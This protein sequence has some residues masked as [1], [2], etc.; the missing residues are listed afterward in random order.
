MIRKFKAPTMKEAMRMAKDF[1]GDD[2]VILSSR[3]VKE[4]ALSNTD[5]DE[6]V[7]ITVT[8]EKNA[9]ANNDI[10]KVLK[11]FYTAA[12]AKTARSKN[13]EP[14]DNRR[15]EKDILSLAAKQDE[16]AALVEKQQD[17]QD[18]LKRELHDIRSTLENLRE[19]IRRSN[20]TLLPDT[21]RELEKDSGI[22]PELANELIQ[23]IFL[24][25]DGT[26]IKD[27]ARIRMALRAEI[28]RQLN[29]GPKFDLPVGRPK[30]ICMVG[31]TGMGKT[32][33]I[34]KLAT[35]PEYYGRKRVGLITIDTYRVA[36][37]AQ[38]KTF[39]A[40]AK[41]PL[42]IVYEPADFAAALDKMREQDVVLI[43]TAGRSP[44]NDTHLQDLRSIFQVAQPDEL[45]LV[46]SSSMRADV[47]Y[48][49]YESFTVL[50]VNHII[51]TKIDETRRLGNILNISRK[52]P[53]PI[54]FLTNGQKVPDDIL[55]ADKSE[56]AHLVVE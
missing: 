45:H 47:L 48:D 37:A 1:F 23:N 15:Y 44:L 22:E 54:S 19:D 38:L 28:V 52:I 9:S 16:V 51:I 2:A 53:L 42:E 17:D 20:G 32:T 8:G 4:P 40:L 24:Q 10:R 41:L 18:T 30:L 29:V 11:P 43:D 46:L 6:M 7:E 13:T 33:T 36:A 27:H 49:A 12:S 26:D 21:R 35:H 5:D 50:P 55:L 31:P 39:A 3:K 25:L 14:S 34:T 56:I